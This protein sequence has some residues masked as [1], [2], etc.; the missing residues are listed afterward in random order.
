MSYDFK[1]TEEEKTILRELAKKQLEYSN[2]PIMQERANLWYDHNSLNGTKPLIV[3]EM[4]LFENDLLPKPR[5]HSP[6]AREIEM[7]INRWIT[8]HQCIDDDKVVPSY[9]TINWRIYIRQFGLDFHQKHAKDTNGKDLGYSWEHKIHD[10]KKDFDILKPSIYS[11]DKEYTKAWKAFVEEIIGDILPVRI[12]NNSLDWFISPSM[13]IVHLMG[14]ENMM[15]SIMDY[16]EEMHRLY[17][18]ITDDIIRFLKWQ[19]KEGLLVLNNENDYAG[20]GSYGFTRDLPGKGYVEGNPVTPRD[21]WVNMN[22]QETV[23]ISPSM[24]EEFILPY[25]SELAENSG[26]VYFGCCEPLHDIWER[27]ISKIPN[28]RKVSISAWCN[29]EFMGE[30]LRS[31]KVIYSRKPSPNFIGVEKNFNEEAFRNHIIKTLNAARGC[32]LEFIFRDIYTLWGD[33]SKAGKAVKITRE[34]IDKLWS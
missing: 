17:R 27:A 13:K 2:L 8:N 22:S 19:E 29:E 34:L 11:V 20:A 7:E 33:N 31:S 9:Y 6:A 24:F 28:L 5:C 3:M 12:K 32:S 30:A 16:P 4:L 10:L 1:V 18:F 23:G 25:Y 26:L 14:L 15:Y 21:M